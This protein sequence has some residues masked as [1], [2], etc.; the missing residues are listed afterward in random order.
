MSILKF[1]KTVNN[2]TYL[3]VSVLG[4]SLKLNVKYTNTSSIDLN[5]KETEIDLFL[6][7]KYKKIENI[8]VINMSIKKLYDTIAET[9][10]EYAMEVARHILKFAPEDYSIKRLNNEFYRCS[11]NKIII[12]PDIV[13]FNRNIINT[14][15]I[16]AFCKIK[17]RPNSIAYKE[18]LNSAMNKYDIY[19][20]N[21][22]KNEFKFLRVS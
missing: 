12:N 15:I 7:K 21:K 13:R 17:F 14:T 19:K 18:L 3:T 11:K 1:K 2:Q 9:E 10:I 20:N 22:T 16:Q 8:D 4:N 5:K 6:P